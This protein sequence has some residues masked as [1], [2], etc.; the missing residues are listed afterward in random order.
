MN[1]ADIEAMLPKA[2]GGRPNAVDFFEKLRTTPEWRR[3]RKLDASWY[4]YEKD[5]SSA[6]DYG[7]RRF[8]S[9]SDIDFRTLEEL[10]FDK[11]FRNLI[12]S[13][14]SIGEYYFVHY[15]FDQ[16]YSMV[17]PRT[18]A[19]IDVARLLV[20]DIEYDLWRMRGNTE[21]P[22]RAELL[23][24]IDCLVKLSRYFENGPTFIEHLSFLVLRA[25]AFEA[26]VLAHS[27]DLLGDDSA[28][29]L[30]EQLD[31]DHVAGLKL[32]LDC[33]RLMA[34]SHVGKVISGE[35][36]TREY[37]Y[38]STFNEPNFGR[39]ISAALPAGFS[40][41][42]ITFALAR[43]EEDFAAVRDFESHDASQFQ[44]R[45]ADDESME[46]VFSQQLIPSVDNLLKL[47]A[48]DRATLVLLKVG[49][50]LDR[51]YRVYSS[52]PDRLEDLVPRYI[53]EIP[54]DSFSPDNSPLI[55]C[56]AEGQFRLYSVGKNQI[57]DGGVRIFHHDSRGDIVFT[58]RGAVFSESE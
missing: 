11:G 32:M 14:I 35:L 37:W 12:E 54:R 42:A 17:R 49:F 9:F 50:A 39:R 38:S 30:L 48:T 27:E 40:R 36:D 57:D 10:L 47:H 2:E 4:E 56:R 1:S 44:K 22:L 6:S 8:E 21:Y 58:G 33:E 13:V 45:L 23:R 26:I 34:C 52:Y 51:F 41:P 18:S 3:I 19:V 53:E 7:I 46:A 28:A 16:G 29:K 25:F 15:D 31:Y 5:V 55:Y 20:K 43:L 24:K